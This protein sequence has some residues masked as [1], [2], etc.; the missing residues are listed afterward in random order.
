M[1][2]K[3]MG[4]FG[5]YL[6]SIQNSFSD[7]VDFYRPF[8]IYYEYKSSYAGWL[9]SV[10]EEAFT[11]VGGHLLQAFFV[12]LFPDCSGGEPDVLYQG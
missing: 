3:S 7:I 5:E 6:T 2:L 1:F 8:I 9:Q 4:A 12:C 10:G 11:D